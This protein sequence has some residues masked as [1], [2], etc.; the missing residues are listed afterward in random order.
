MGKLYELLAVE[1]NLKSEAAQ[2]ISK[3]KGLFLEGKK[4]FLGQ[5][6]TY[7]PLEENGEKFPDEI[8]N[9]A[10]TIDDELETF[11]T[12]FARWIDAAVQKEVT[13]KKT[14]ASIEIDGEILVA[15]LPAPA[16][17]NLESKLAELRQIYAAIPTNDPSER[18]ELD[19][20]LG[21][22]VSNPRITHKTKKV[23]RAHVLYDAT[24]EHPA[25]VESFTEDMRVGEWTTIIHSGM[26]TPVEKQK[27]LK[28]VDT[29]LRAVKKARQRANDVD[30]DDVKIAKKFFDY[31]N[32]E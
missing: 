23:P 21:C 22:F 7:A 25:Q 32:R 31:I 17:L 1:S 27:R 9:L 19:E 4:N 20:Q 2:A 10:T 18:W 30:V 15:D 26:L 29:L 28:R 13:N 14:S 16:L 8:T 24:P 11:Q 5:L 3:I 6:R 12:A